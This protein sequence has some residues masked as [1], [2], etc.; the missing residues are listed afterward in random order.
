[1]DLG[2]YPATMAAMTVMIGGVTQ[3]PDSLFSSMA[4][5]EVSPLQD[6]LSCT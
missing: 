1:M 3:V 5:I 2:S 4:L 6:P